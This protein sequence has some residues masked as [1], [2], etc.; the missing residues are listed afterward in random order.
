[1]NTNVNKTNKNKFNLLVADSDKEESASIVD[2]LKNTYNIKKAE[3]VDEA[4]RILRNNNIHI[5]ISGQDFDGIEFLKKTFEISPKALKVLI[6]DCSDSNTLINAINTAK[7][8]R[9]LKKPCKI[10]ELMLVMK[11]ISEY[12]DLKAENDKLILDLKKLFTGTVSAIT[13]ALDGT[14]PYI[15]GKSRRVAFCAIKL[16][17]Y[18]KLPEEEI[19]KIDLAGLLHDIGMIAIPEKVLNKPGK[20]SEEEKLILKQ[21]IENGIGI[22]KDIKQFKDILEIIK[23]H[24]EQYDGNGYPFGL[25]GEEIPLASQ[26]IAIADAYDG[27]ISDRTYRKGFEHDEAIKKLRQRTSFNSDLVE[28]FILAM[29]ESLEEFK[30]FEKE[31]KQL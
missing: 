31:L 6:T 18:L 17:R 9:Y 28:K 11:S 25:K 10:S 20:F 22:L 3:T 5:I 29:N 12:L 24:H 4:L 7:I 14:N 13:D 15:F 16:A 26:I 21:H 19:G 27:L 8:Y 23:Y 2:A 1:M 30:N